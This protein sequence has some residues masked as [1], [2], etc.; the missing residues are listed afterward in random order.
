MSTNDSLTLSMDQ[1]AK[2]KYP[3][4]VSEAGDDIQLAVQ[5]TETNYKGDWNESSADLLE[6]WR[7]K[8]QE[9]AW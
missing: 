3:Y 4:P 5:A 6:K 2:K 8:C 7:D 9:Q 1:P